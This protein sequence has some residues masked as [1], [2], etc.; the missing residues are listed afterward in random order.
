MKQ[1]NNKTKL[2]HIVG[3][4]FNQLPLVQ[5]AKQM[6][7]KVLVTDMNVNPPCKQYSDYY[8]QINTTNKQATLSCAE[9]Y[10]IDY[11]TTDQTDV[12]VPTV[13]FIAEKLGLRGIGYSTALKFT[14]KYVM[15]RALKGLLDEHIPECY[16]FDNELEA[17]KFCNEL[18]KL[19]EYVVKPV[20]SQG[21]KGVTIL[22]HKYKQMLATAFR[23]SID[24]G[25]IIERYISGFEFSVESFV[26]DEK[27]YNLTLT[28]KYH[29]NTNPCLD[30]RNT[31]LGDID[32]L[33]EKRIF[34]VNAKMIKALGLPFGNTH[35]E[36]K[37]E[38]GNVYLIE[39]AA[40]GAGGSI[41]SSIIPFLTGF[42]P[43]EALLKTLTGVS[44]EI[45]ID[46]YKKKYAVLKF[47]NFAPGKVKKIYIDKNLINNVL[48]FNF[49]LKE[50]D[51]I[52]LVKDSRDR[53]G[54]FIVSGNDRDNVLKK[55]KMVESFVQVEYFERSLAIN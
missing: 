14:N 32:P 38:D 50:G 8:E 37:V 26:K 36:Y 45:K 34:D 53:P 33:L 4:G 5:K 1:Q 21:S 23:E 16:Y 47:F 10:K 35:A 15:R 13:A 6:D 2:I 3:G 54:Y 28:K 31:F 19:S 44:F 11:I 49:N 18:P 48:V 12:A 41:N 22:D 52:N 9:K 20:N 43:L 42:D 25:I 24:R 46:D 51:T 39:I 30:E 7:Y 17:E 55:E 40:R 29:Y 27:V